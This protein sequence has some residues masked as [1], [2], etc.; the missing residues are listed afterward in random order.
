[1]SRLPIAGSASDCDINGVEISFAVSL[2][3]RTCLAGA[4]ASGFVGMLEPWRLMALFGVIAGAYPPA[5]EDDPELYEGRAEL[6]EAL[7]NVADDLE[8]AADAEYCGVA[9]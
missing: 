3:D 7:V 2:P 8:V 1:M 6:V 4:E 9:A 5:E